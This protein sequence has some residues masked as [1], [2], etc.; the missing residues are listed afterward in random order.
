MWPV[1]FVAI[2]GFPIAMNSGSSRFHPSA[3]AGKTPQSATI[4][5]C[6][7][8]ICDGMRVVSNRMR[9]TIGPAM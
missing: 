6:A 7:T 2:T 3:R 4:M 8:S 5:N 1:T 9:S